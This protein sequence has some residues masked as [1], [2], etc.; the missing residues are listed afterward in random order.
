[1]ASNNVRSFTPKKRAPKNKASA[2]RTDGHMALIMSQAQNGD[3]AEIWAQHYV[4]HKY[5]KLGLT[6]ISGPYGKGPDFRGV[7]KGKR[8]YIEVERTPEN[9]LVH[10]HNYDPAF[11]KVSVLIVLASYIDLDR[12]RSLLP[13]TIL[14][15]DLED[16]AKWALPQMEREQALMLINAI[17]ESLRQEYKQKH[18]EICGEKERDMA[19]CPECDLCPY[20]GEESDLDPSSYL[21]KMASYPK[22]RRRIFNKLTRGL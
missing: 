11:K 4:L 20:F 8:V 9:Y 21:E 6:D 16:F 18:F 19:A 12:V 13:K 17:D 10:G 1:M 15:I 7:Y 5:R 22:K 3:I 14:N 2:A